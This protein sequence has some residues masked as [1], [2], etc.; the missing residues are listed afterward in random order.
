MGVKDVAG[1][2]GRFAGDVAFVVGGRDGSDHS[3][4]NLAHENLFDG[5]DFILRPFAAIDVFGRECQAATPTIE[6]APRSLPVRGQRMVD[7]RGVG[8]D[9]LFAVDRDECGK[10]G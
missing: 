10:V 6:P 9:K 5:A 7:G 2:R 4:E 8:G 1:D 3:R